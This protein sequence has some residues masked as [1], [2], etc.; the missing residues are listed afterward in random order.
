[1]HKAALNLQARCRGHQPYPGGL[2]V[3][4]TKVASLQD[5]CCSA[6]T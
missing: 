3:G 6:E 1:L 5:R 2:Q 4:F